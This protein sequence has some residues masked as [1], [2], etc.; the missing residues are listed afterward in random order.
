MLTDST[1]PSR[2]K[3]AAFLVMFACAALLG[4]GCAAKDPLQA[5]LP[6]DID[7]NWDVRPILSDNCFRCHGHDEKKRE[8]GLRLD[9]RDTAIAE[10]PESPGKHAIVPGDPDG[11]EL[12]RRITN[13]DPDERMPPPETHKVLSDRDIAILK[14]WIDD[15]ARYKA[16]W[17]YV[18]PEHGKPPRSKFSGQAANDIDRFV[19]AK[20][21][22]EGLTPSA[23]ADAETLINRVTLTLTGL[24]SSL[25][26]VDAFVADKSPDAYEKLVDRLLASPAYAEHMATQWL[27]VAR[28]SESDGFLDDAHN[29]LFWPYRDWVINSLAKN[30]PFNEFG[31]WQIAGDILAKAE[32]D[33]RRAREETLATAFLRVGRRTTENGAIDE[34]YRVENVIDRANTVGT[35]FLGL[36][37]GCAQC[38]DH[39]YDP[40]SHADFYALTGFFNSNDEPGYYAFGVSGIQQGPTL[41]WTDAETDAKIAAAAKEIEIREAAYRAARDAAAARQA[42]VPADLKRI[43]AV[44]EQSTVG[45]FPFDTARTI[46]DAEV[47][48]LNVSSPPTPHYPPMQL[49]MKPIPPSASSAGAPPA[50]IRGGE[51]RQRRN[52]FIPPPGATIKP[53]E[54]VLAGMRRGD[55]RASPNLVPG[56]KPAIIESPLLRPGIRGNA[57]YFDD[58]NKGFLEGDLGRFERTQPFSVDVW[59]R[60]GEAYKEATVFSNR[61]VDFLGGQGYALL[62]MDNH[63]RFSMMHSRAGNMIRVRSRQPIPVGGWTHVSVTYDGSSRA[64]GLGLYVNGV[65]AEVDVERDNLTRTVLPAGG[66]LSGPFDA[67][68]GFAFGKRFRDFTLKDGALDELRVFN[69][70]LTPLEVR[71]LHGDEAVLKEQPAD[72]QRD[73]KEFSV[74]TDA[75]VV[76]AEKALGQAREAHNLLVSVQPQIMVMGD[77][78]T[79]RSTYVLGKGLYSNHEQEVEPQGLTQVFP[80][81]AALPRDRFGLAQWLFDPKNPLTARVFVNRVWQMHFG[82]GLVETAEDFGAQGSIPSHPELLDWLATGFVQSGWDLKALHKLIV[83]TATYRQSSN[84]TDEL[85]ERDPQNRLLARGLRIRMPAEMVRDQALA[86]SG[87]LVRQVGGPS[88]YPYQPEGIWSQWIDAVYPDANAVPDDQ[89]HRRSIYSSVKRS[90]PHPAMAVFDLPER[91]VTNA[92]RRTSNTPLQAL[93]LLNDPQYLEA[94][95]NLAAQALKVEDADL[96]AQIVRVFRLATR[97]PPRADEL[98]LLRS[99]YQTQRTEFASHPDKAGQLLSI[100]VAPVP[101]DADKI[102]LAAL[103]NVTAAVMNTPDAYSIR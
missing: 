39:K 16:H 90:A 17:A 48:P 94:Y 92:R 54:V 71:Y 20:L 82:K 58:T 4:A 73:L 30:M 87:L 68:V 75:A 33:P 79:P 14:A 27:D 26:E 41:P 46:S 49:P 83:M 88:T 7:Y 100:G 96:D 70:R 101:A 28:Y 81:N 63:L 61:E 77:T 65:P 80:W 52:S 6:D 89:H 98:A 31:T 13:T 69:R 84:A 103:T 34:E 50:G 2:P 40:I 8:A 35:G 60:P 44:I 1:Q 86:A 25:E 18:A 12:I 24:P 91:N 93:V 57:L 72:L 38:H 47:P 85:L 97:R 22:K 42:A 74:A 29:R 55:L 3:G 36:T 64:A 102:E 5:S 43:K 62:L 9:V 23:A 76:G 21:E 59:V 32:Q 66:R 10:L 19:F 37:T 11:S 51:A 56:G 67:Y 53:D 95:R 15:G 45:Y 99:Y 78:P